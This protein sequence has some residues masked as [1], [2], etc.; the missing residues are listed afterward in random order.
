VK[1]L[2]L[3][4]ALSLSGCASS[5][6]SVSFEPVEPRSDFLVDVRESVPDRPTKR[7]SLSVLQLSSVGSMAPLPSEG[8]LAKMRSYAANYGANYLF[9]ERLDTPWRRAFYATGMKFSST[10]EGRA[11]ECLHEGFMNAVEDVVQSTGRCLAEMQRARR[12]LRATVA[13]TLVVDSFGGLMRIVHDEDSSRDSL[14]RRCLTR[15]AVKGDYGPHGNY[16][17]TTKVRLELQ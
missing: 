17:C 14:V 1:H 9:V 8:D 3:T 11:P 6:V 5:M 16:T 13:A 10:E 2:A 12:S 7:V 4:L 15:A